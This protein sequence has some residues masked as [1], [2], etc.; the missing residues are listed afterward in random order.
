MKL[1]SLNLEGKRHLKTALPFLEYEKPDCVALMEATVDTQLW[2]QERD[3]MTTFSPMAN[4]SQDGANFEIGLLFASKNTH[5]ATTHYYYR[6]E[7]DG[8]LKHREIYPHIKISHPVIFASLQNINIAVTHFTWNPNGETADTYQ[9]QDLEALL[10][11]LKNKPTHILCG[12]FNIPRHLN[13]L[14][15]ELV[16]YYKD[17]IPLEYESSLDINLHRLRND[18]INQNVFRN[19]M[20]DYLFTQ[21]PYKALNT[22]LEFGVSDH[23]AIVTTIDSSSQI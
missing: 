2:L 1:V 20:V 3:Y 10:L 17:E 12:D 13:N 15:D 21:P 5:T 7:L 14:Y 16:K 4:I 23:A 19:F 6:P 11:Y 8:I 9:T 22:R 18:P